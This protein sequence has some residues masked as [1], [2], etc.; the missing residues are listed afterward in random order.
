MKAEEEAEEKEGKKLKSTP[1]KEGK[2]A[3]KKVQAS[4]HLKRTKRV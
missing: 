4:F 2:K 3:R 1:E